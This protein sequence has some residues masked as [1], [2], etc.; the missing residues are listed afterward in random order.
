MYTADHLILAL[1]WIGYFA[2][3][4]LTASLWL[5]RWMAERWPR[6]MP[7]YRLLFNGVAGLLILPLLGF[8]Y[9]L[10]G[11][12]LWRWQGGGFFIANG[13]ALAALAGFAWSLR[14]Y[15]GQ[16]FL[17]LRQ[18]RHRVAAVEDQERF[19]LSPL[20]RYVRHPWYSLGLVLVWTRDMEPAL[21]LSAILVTAYFVLGSRL[22]ER[23]LIAYH[24]ERYRRYR[25]RV[26]ALIPWKGRA[27]TASEAEFLVGG[28]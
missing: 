15:D 27:L 24:G 13:L 2:L 19:H 14:W 3:H 9:S 8:M 25:E 20:H 21:L 11:A 5:K 28:G 10:Q 6:L 26:P 18:L 4:S 23:K 22:E 16:E 7:F 1:A 12:W 17:G